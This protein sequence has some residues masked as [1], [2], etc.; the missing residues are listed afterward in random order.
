MKSKE[1]IFSRPR[2]IST[3]KRPAKDPPRRCVCQ[4]LC[5]DKDWLPSP[6]RRDVASG[7]GW[8]KDGLAFAHEQDA[9]VSSASF[10]RYTM[11]LSGWGMAGGLQSAKTQRTR[12]RRGPVQSFGCA[13]RRQRIPG[14]PTP[15]NGSGIAG[16]PDRIRAGRR[17]RGPRQRRGP[18]GLLATVPAPSHGRAVGFP[19]KDRQKSSVA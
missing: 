19:W 12:S 9:P 4:P 2:L 3:E 16:A 13:A 5:I 7:S 6:S 10:A 17:R 8:R 11:G 18:P 14:D 15:R 1:C